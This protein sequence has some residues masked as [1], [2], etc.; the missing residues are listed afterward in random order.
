MSCIKIGK[1]GIKCRNFPIRNWKFRKSRFRNFMYK[2]WEFGTFKFTNHN[3]DLIFSI[4]KVLL[5]NIETS[6]SVVW[7][8]ATN[9]RKISFKSINFAKFMLKYSKFQYFIFKNL[10]VLFKPGFFFYIKIIAF[11]SQNVALTIRS[12]VL[13]MQKF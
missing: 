7:N 5:S 1:F 6:W 3:F 4:W 8:F 2:S 9:S 11:K 10:H 13:E 12:L